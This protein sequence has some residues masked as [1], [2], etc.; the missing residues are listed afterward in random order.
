M[1]RDSGNSSHSTPVVTRPVAADW[2]GLRRAADHEARQNAAPVIKRI[3]SW[4]DERLNAGQ[5]AVVIDLGAGTGSNQA[6]LAPRLTVP[7]QWILVDHDAGLL[8]ASTATDAQQ[9]RSTTRMVGTVHQLPELVGSEAPT[10]VTCAALL[11]LL[12]PQEATLIAQTIASSQAA[13]LL[14]LTVTGHVSLTPEDPVDHQV[15]AAFD[16]HQRR[17][18]LLGPDAAEVVAGLLR[19]NGVDVEVVETD[20]VLDAAQPELVERYL[21]DRAN[22]AVEQNPDLAEAAQQWVQRR[23]VQLQHGDLSVRVGHQD[24][25]CIPEA[26]A[27]S[28]AG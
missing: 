12:S 6:W 20:W 28:S 17:E 25:V 7:Q 2:L 21:T 19:E 14:S 5:A 23:R 1:E 13:A 11:D 9:V 4:L 16:A 15:A 24:V 27:A 18:D 3:S 26:Q 10:L 8:D 22:A